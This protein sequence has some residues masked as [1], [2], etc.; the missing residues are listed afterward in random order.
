[1][2][3]EKIKDENFKSTLEISKYGES[4]KIPFK[5]IFRDENPNS[6]VNLSKEIRKKNNGRLIIT[7]ED[8]P[9]EEYSSFTSEMPKNLK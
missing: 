4:K 2:D 9:D 6:T 5:G 1:M 3:K 8:F 7:S